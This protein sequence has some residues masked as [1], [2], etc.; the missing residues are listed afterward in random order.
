MA[1]ES[2]N[3]PACTA[4]RPAIVDRIGVSRLNG[5]PHRCRRP[6]HRAGRVVR[7]RRLG[8]RYAGSPLDPRPE[9]LSA[10]IGRRS[11]SRSGAR[12]IR[13]TPRCPVADVHLRAATVESASTIVGTSSMGRANHVRLRHGESG[14][15]GPDR[16]ARLRGVHAAGTRSND[17]P[18][19]AR[20]RA[21]HRPRVVPNPS[22][23]RLVP[24]AP[25]TPNGRSGRGSRSR[26]CH[27][28]GV[29]AATRCRKTRLHGT[30]RPRLRSQSDR[31]RVRSSV[32]QHRP[33]PLIP[34]VGQAE[35]R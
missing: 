29:Y 20:G 19:R 17:E 16:N 9:S 31:S 25:G 11:G 1:A 6:R 30:D 15:V 23:R 14:A 7:D 35:G 26:A 12:W 5:G 27:T 32:V 28:R 24:A 33:L 18:D 8:R 34:T 10:L 4:V 21:H 3:G 22:S 2:S 13:S